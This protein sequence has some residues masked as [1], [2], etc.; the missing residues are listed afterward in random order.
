VVVVVLVVRDMSPSAYLP[1]AHGR[2]SNGRRSA[3]LPVYS[4]SF[5]SSA[6]QEKFGHRHLSPWL[7]SLPLPGVRKRLRLFCLNPRRLYQ[8]SI[9][10]F[11][12]VKG[13]VILSLGYLVVLFFIFALAKRFGTRE[14]KWPRPFLGDPPTLIYRREDLQR[15]WRWE[16]ASGHY[17][18]HQP[19]K[20]ANLECH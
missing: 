18:S 7:I 15:I 1:N 12:R 5:S 11:G 10:R 13:S 20:Q 3:G 8:S 14:R 2:P 17:P 6:V 19:S 9:L 16:I 4:T